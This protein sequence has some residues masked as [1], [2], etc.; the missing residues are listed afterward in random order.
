MNLWGDIKLVALRV[1]VT[2]TYGND[3]GMKQSSL[4]VIRLFEMF[5]LSIARTFK[6]LHYTETTG[7]FGQHDEMHYIF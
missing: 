2:D 4:Q 7:G 6:E 1:A 3:V 5:G